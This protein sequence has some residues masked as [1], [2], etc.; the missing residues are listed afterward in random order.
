MWNL[1]GFLVGKELAPHHPCPAPTVSTLP[2][3]HIKSISVVTLASDHLDN[4]VT[5]I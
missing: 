1:E 4:G 3:L 2:A 5:S